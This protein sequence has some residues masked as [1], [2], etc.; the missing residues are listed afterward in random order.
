MFLFFEIAVENIIKMNALQEN[1][2]SHFHLNRMHYSAKF[3]ASPN[4]VDFL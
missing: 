4:A 3:Q 2:T 1:S